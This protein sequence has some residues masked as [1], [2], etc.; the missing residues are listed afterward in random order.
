MAD[1]SLL[2]IGVSIPDI[3]VSLQSASFEL[4]CIGV[5]LTPSNVSLLTFTPVPPPS[6]NIVFNFSNVTS[7]MYVPLLAGFA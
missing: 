4:A 3:Q 1:V 2:R 5:N 6:G 7:S